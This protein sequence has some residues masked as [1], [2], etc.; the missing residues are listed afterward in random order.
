MTK[1]EKIAKLEIDLKE[2]DRII[3]MLERQMML[4]FKEIEALEDKLAKRWSKKKGTY[5]HRDRKVVEPGSTQKRNWDPDFPV[6]G[7]RNK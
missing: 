6:Y 7:S 2:K 4:A 5:P 1:D 3:T